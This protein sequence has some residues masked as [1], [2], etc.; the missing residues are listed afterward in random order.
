MNTLTKCDSNQGHMPGLTCN[1]LTPLNVPEVAT[2]FCQAH[3]DTALRV[4]G[5]ASQYHG[6]NLPDFICNALF[7][8]VICAWFAAEY[9]FFKVAPTK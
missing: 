1:R 4:V 8:N 6:V 2:V 7:Q 9:S 5:S 3:L